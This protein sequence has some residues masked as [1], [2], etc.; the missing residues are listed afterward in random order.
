MAGARKRTNRSGKFQGWFVD[1]TGKR[2]FFT[3]TH[4]KGETLAMAR[5]LEDVRRL[6][7]ELQLSVYISE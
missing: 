2:K 7:S 5:K 3:L 1:A 6:G 4:D